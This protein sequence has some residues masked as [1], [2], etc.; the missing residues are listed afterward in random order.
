MVSTGFMRWG[1]PDATTD[2]MCLFC[3]R[4]VA[5]SQDQADLLAAEDDH[6]CNPFDDLGFLHSDALQG[7]RGQKQTTMPC[8]DCRAN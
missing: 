1:D 6:I 2:I 3:F 5:R 4:T 8:E 7:L